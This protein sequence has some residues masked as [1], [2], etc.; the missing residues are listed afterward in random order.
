[1]SESPFSEPTWA[2]VELFGH[3]LI[4]G[5]VSEVA[6]AGVAMLRV[7]VPAVDG[8][9][10]FTKFYGGAAVYAITPTDQESAL[11]AVNHLQA[12]PIAPWTIPMR[13]KKLPARVIHE[14]N[15]D[16]GLE[17]GYWMTPDEEDEDEEDEED[18]S[19]ERYG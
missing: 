10:A 19:L 15:E 7:D 13:V 9:P 11:H 1:M 18:D 17:L 2:I 4:A 8:S 14:D 16:D 6:V 5:Q 12:L 3:N